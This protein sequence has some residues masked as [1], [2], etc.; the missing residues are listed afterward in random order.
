MELNGR[1]T[2]KEG[3]DLI[4]RQSGCSFIFADPTTVLI[5]PVPVAVIP[6]RPPPTLEDIAVVATRL[7]APIARSPYAVSSISEATLE[8]LGVTDLTD[9]APLVAG[10]TTTNLGSGRDKIFLRGISDGILT[11]RTQSTVG[12][13]LDEVALSYNAPDPDLRLTDLESVEVLRGPQGAL[14]GSGSIGGVIQ[15]RSKKPA[16]DQFSARVSTEIG[17]TQGAA[18]S[19]AIDAMINLP[20]VKD[21][22]AIRGVGYAEQAGG[23]IDNVTTDLKDINKVQRSGARLAL[24]AAFDQGWTLTL[25]AGFQAINAADTQYDTAG[26]G[27]YQ[28][29]LPI[30]EP[31]DND[32]DALYA[33]VEHRDGG[34]LV[35]STTALVRHQ[36]DSRYDAT[37]SLNL[38]AP[39]ASG[40]AAFDDADHKRIFTQEITAASSFNPRVQWLAGLNYQRDTEFAAPI[41]HALSN[42]SPL[43]SEDRSS[44]VETYALFGEATV[45]PV[46]RVHLTFGARWTQTHSR[47][48]STV[49]AQ[50]GVRSTDVALTERRLAPKIVASFDL[51]EAAIVYVQAAEGYRSGGVNTGGLAGQTFAPSGGV[52]QP[53][54]V[55]KGDELWNYELG[56]KAKLL[57][58]ALNL[59]AATY[60]ERWRDLQ[61]NQLL[62]SGLSYV[63]NVGVANDLGVEFE[64]AVVPAPDVIVRANLTLNDPELERRTPSFSSIADAQLPGV[65]RV[66][67]AVFLSRRFSLPA[68]YQGDVAMDVAY[69][70][71]S[72]ISIDPTTGA[73]MGGYTKTRLSF[74]VTKDHWSTRVVLDNLANQASDTFAFGNPFSIRSIGQLTPQRPRSVTL[75]ISRSF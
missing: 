26:L 72:R 58:G 71:R 62:P 7:P 66:S 50:D 23:Y 37:A 59:R 20:I 16:L 25:G 54:Q 19:S 2:V 12:V 44:L 4:L 35:R 75:K 31:H 46:R 10:M 6:S 65:S 29:A 8:R 56:L 45:S 64:A 55:Y 15:L 24:L 22:L 48:G 14:Y 33:V 61:S 60:A 47:V 1:H 11:G 39:G 30:A 69:V 67:A 53:Y 17:T 51:S 63:A 32:F 28:R 13:Y 52:S 49:S 70:G 74:G 40:P 43:Y 41:L 38:L 42:N 27:P 36:I 5:I 3:L 21:R 34:L 9:A 18:S 73:Q 68:G 57:G